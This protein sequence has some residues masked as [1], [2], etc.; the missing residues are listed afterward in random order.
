MAKKVDFRKTNA[1]NVP[2]SVVI[3]TYCRERWQ[4]VLRDTTR[5]RRARRKRVT[6][7]TVVDTRACHDQD[8]QVSAAMPHDLAGVS[9]L[10]DWPR[11]KLR[12][13]LPSARSCLF[14]GGVQHNPCP[15]PSFDSNHPRTQANVH[16]S[17]QSPPTTTIT[18]HNTL[19][20]L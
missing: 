13:R 6:K 14:Q 10:G 7:K 11:A 17:S 1:T 4:M 2:Q 18:R 15:I 19:H 8:Q 5:Q 12:Q 16:V 3:E 9:K 20:L